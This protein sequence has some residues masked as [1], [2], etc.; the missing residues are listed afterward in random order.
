MQKPAE[1]GEI[2]ARR[3]WGFGEDVVRRLELDGGGGGC[4]CVCAVV[5]TEVWLGELE[6][7]LN[8]GAVCKNLIPTESS[9]AYVSYIHTSTPPIRIFLLF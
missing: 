4:M 5:D 6:G 2:S 7:E 3:G 9:A 1:N 8:I